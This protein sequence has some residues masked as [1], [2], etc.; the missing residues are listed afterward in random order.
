MV[1]TVYVKNRRERLGLSQHRAAQSVGWTAQ[2]WSDFEN[3]RNPD[4]RISTLAAV[5]RALRCGIGSL[6]LDSKPDSKGRRAVGRKRK[7]T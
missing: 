1:N 2:R 6:V 7:Q 5:A 3:G 4:P